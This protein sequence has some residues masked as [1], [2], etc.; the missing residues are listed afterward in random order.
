MSDFGKQYTA[1]EEIKRLQENIYQL[2]ECLVYVI[3]QSC[4]SKIENDKF[5]LDDMAISAYE[6]A[7]YLLEKYGIIKRTLGRK[8]WL[9]W[10]ALKRQKP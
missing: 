1:E 2:L 3:N 7:F 5:Y 9:D 6:D 10:E 8:P 4:Q